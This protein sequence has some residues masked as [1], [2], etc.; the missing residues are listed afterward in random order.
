MV[1]P[2]R[3]EGVMLGESFSLIMNAFPVLAGI[4]VLLAFVGQGAAQTIIQDTLYRNYTQIWGTLP[5]GT[6]LPGGTYQQATGWSYNQISFPSFESDSGTSANNGTGIALS[7][8]SSGTYVKPTVFEVSVEVNIA[9]P[10][11][12]TN[13]PF[14]VFGFYSALEASSNPPAYLDSRSNFTGLLLASDGSLSLYDDGSLVD[15]STVAYAGGTFVPGTF[16]TLSYTVDTTT[17]SISGICLEGSTADYSALVASGQPFTP[18]YTAYLGLGEGADFAP[19][20]GGVRFINLS[21]VAI[22]EP[23]TAAL[24]GAA[25]LGSLLRRRRAA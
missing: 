16:Y 5:T 8:S 7:L 12:V 18:A 17:G 21:V 25:G 20:N 10:S 22:P 14:A 11:P 9:T 3:S 6:N 13:T 23:A 2:L 4:L 19:Y 24:V 1:L 15:E